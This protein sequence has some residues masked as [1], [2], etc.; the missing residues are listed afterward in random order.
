MELIKTEIDGLLIIK[1]NV[2]EDA[3]GYFYES[4]NKDFLENITFVQ[5]NESKSCKNVIRGMHFQ[6]PPYE[7]GKL[8]RVIKGSVLDVAVDIRKY[9][10]T[11]KQWKSIV[12]SEQNKLM[13]WIQPGFAHGFRALEDDTIL[14]YKCTNLYNKESERSFIWN[15]PDIN[16]DWC[17]SNPIISEKDKNSPTFKIIE[18][19]D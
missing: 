12:L 3:R 15:D 13:F 7:Q 17:I 11:Y 2:F 19:N 10:P 5:D 4:Y 14:F 18:S 1:P 9:S 8:I 6:I 16:I